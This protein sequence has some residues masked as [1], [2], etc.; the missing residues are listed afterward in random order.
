MPKLAS[1]PLCTLLLFAIATHTLVVT[2]SVQCAI[3]SNLWSP[4]LSMSV[5][6]TGM[7]H[8]FLFQQSMRSMTWCFQISTCL[9]H[10]H[11]VESGADNPVTISLPLRV[12]PSRTRG[13]SD[14]VET[15]LKV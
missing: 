1:R 14:S 3:V 5:R 12:A 10:N 9:H 15:R 8:K 13:P 7:P 6:E 2:G 11:L 4:F